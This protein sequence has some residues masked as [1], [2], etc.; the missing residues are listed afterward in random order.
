M[1]DEMCEGTWNDVWKW[2]KGDLIMCEGDEMMVSEGDGMIC[3]RDKI[4]CEGEETVV[5]ALF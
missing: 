2:W 5:C 1:S 4:V 3:E